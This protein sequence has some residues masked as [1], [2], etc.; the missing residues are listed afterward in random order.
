MVYN[1]HR[2]QT[3]TSLT[4][5]ENGANVSLLSQSHTGKQSR[6]PWSRSKEGITC[7]RPQLVQTVLLELPTQL[8][9]PIHHQTVVASP[10]G[11][12]LLLPN[13]PTSFR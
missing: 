11:I 1:F 3:D 9:L 4:Y 5:V 7:E 2:E 12:S 10:T 8:Q 6:L 13:P